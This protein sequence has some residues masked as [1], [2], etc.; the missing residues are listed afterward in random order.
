M[1]IKGFNLWV[2][3]LFVGSSFNKLYGGSGYNNNA[4][5][6]FDKMPQKILCYL[7]CCAK[8]FTIL[9]LFLEIITVELARTDS[10]I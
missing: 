2:W 5:F 6:V 4:W 3:V 10:D 1:P 8:W 7:E 9:E